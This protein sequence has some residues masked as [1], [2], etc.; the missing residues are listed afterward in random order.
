MYR[1]GGCVRSLLHVRRAGTQAVT[2][3]E[4][5]G[6]K[7]L[8]ELHRPP[9]SRLEAEAW[10]VP[11]VKSSHWPCKR[12]QASLSRTLSS[13]ELHVRRPETL[14]GQE[15]TAQ[16][17]EKTPDSV[18]S[19]GKMLC[20]CQVRGLW[21]LCFPAASKKSTSHCAPMPQIKLIKSPAIMRVCQPGQVALHSAG[22]RAGLQL[23]R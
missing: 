9:R 2:G 11:Q 10:L 16:V 21:D 18:P 6:S 22:G 17:A 13:S 5:V 20:A 15:T 4:N 8:R 1:A 3:S 19:S 23:R 12:R 7:G 14:Q